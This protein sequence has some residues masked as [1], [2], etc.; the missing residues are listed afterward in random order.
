VVAR[1]DGGRIPTRRTSDSR[2]A[3]IRALTLHI[4]SLLER[5]LKPSPGGWDYQPPAKLHAGTA[6]ELP[7][8]FED[9]FV[10]R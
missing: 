8:S 10:V 7:C 3:G 1:S 9:F 6:E 4:R 5:I 2:H